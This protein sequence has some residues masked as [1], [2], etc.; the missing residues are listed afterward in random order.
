MGV[1]TGFQTAAVSGAVRLRECPL[2][3]LRMYYI[4]LP[5]HPTPANW[6]VR[7]LCVTQ[8]AE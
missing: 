4:S 3:E 5:T 7:L 6:N 1:K 8:S 2:R